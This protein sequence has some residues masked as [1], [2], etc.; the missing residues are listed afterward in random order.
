M[1]NR[2]RQI[3]LTVILAVIIFYCL[4]LFYPG[5]WNWS[6]YNLNN[7]RFIQIILLGMAALALIFPEISRT[8]N[9]GLTSISLTLTRIPRGAKTALLIIVPIILLYILRIHVQIYGDAQNLI[10]SMVDGKITS[11]LFNRI[12]MLLQLVS[13]L[14]G[15]AGG[16]RENADLFLSIVSILA[17]GVFFFYSWKTI[18]VIVENESYRAAAYLALLT[19]G[20]MLIFAGYIETYSIVFAWLVIYAYNL[21]LYD[22]NKIGTV[23]LLI[24]FIIGAVWHVLFMAF[25]PSLIWAINKRYGLVNRWV[26]RFLMA[27][28]IIGMYAAGNVLLISIFKVVLPISSNEFTSYTLFSATHLIDFL[29]E[30]IIVGPVL[31]L[32]GLV[33]IFAGLRD[34]NLNMMVW[35]TVPAL[36][37]AFMLDPLLGAV[38]DWDLLAIFAFPIAILTITA[39]AGGSKNKLGLLLIPIL[40]INMTHITGAI[41][42]NKNESAA[43]ERVVRISLDDPHYQPDY[44]NGSRTQEFSVILSNIFKRH[45]LALSFLERKVDPGMADILALANYHFNQKQYEEACK[46][47]AQVYGKIDMRPTYRFGYGKALIL[48]KHPAEAIPILNTVQTDTAFHQLDYHLGIAHMLNMEIDSGVKYF[49]R[50]L[51]NFPDSVEALQ[52]YAQFLEVFRLP[53]LAAYYE[54]RLYWAKGELSDS[55]D[56]LKHIIENFEAIG[57]TDSADRYREILK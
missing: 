39:L 49:E 41:V 25:L 3:A 10:G 23:R 35:L 29:N 6:V 47:Y 1:S 38:R 15:V 46:Y 24:I 5:Y 55:S 56:L 12:G 53:G 51:V 54:S 34:K 57:L 20:F 52:K 27:A 8:V 22:K 42:I 31:A 43:V 37:L 18:I 50:G 7:I 30:L 21:A 9:Q 2:I 4:S 48:T 32:I 28:F 14:I 36:A 13:N 19:S 33:L 17:G 40:L 44:Y 11:P 26:M 16:S 45:D